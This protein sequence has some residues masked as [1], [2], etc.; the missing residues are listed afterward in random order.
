MGLPEDDISFKT[1]RRIPLYF[2]SWFRVTVAMGYHVLSKLTIDQGVHSSTVPKAKLFC[3]TGNP[4]EQLF[5][6]PELVVLKNPTGSK[7]L[8]S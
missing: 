6:W 7:V 1:R 5:I 4:S 3:F 8:S 2:H